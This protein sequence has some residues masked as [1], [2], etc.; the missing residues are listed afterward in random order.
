MT[1][2]GI[3]TRPFFPKIEPVRTE[4]RNSLQKGPEWI[5]ERLD[6][7]ILCET[8][9][10]RK[11]PGMAKLRIDTLVRVRL[12][13]CGMEVRPWMV[14]AVAL[15]GAAAA[16]AQ[17]IP[18]EPPVASSPAK[19]G[20]TPAASLAEATPNETVVD[21]KVSGNK[22][23]PLEK[24]LPHIRTRAGRPFDMELIQEDVRRLDRTGLFVNVH[25]YHQAAPGGRI[26]IFDVL[27]R[28][29]LH[30]VLFIG[31]KEVRK[32]V[33][34]KEAE[35]KVGDPA[36]PYAIEEARRKLEDFYHKKGFSGARITLLEGDKPDDRRAIFLI[37]E[38]TKQRIWKVE[39]I[40]NTI[41]DDGRLQ[42]Q[43]KSKPP[44]LY[45]FKGELDRKELEE[46][47]QRL[48]A[49]YRGLGFFRARIGKEVSFDEKQNWATVTFVIDE[50]PRYKIRNVSVIGNTKFGSD[51]LLTDLKLKNQE[52][53]NQAKMT[54]DQ[55]SIQDKY[56]G[57]G[58]VFTDVKA[59]PRFL[60]EADQLDLVYN[61]EEGDRYR[62]GKINIVIKG[63]YPHTKI[64]T[65]LNRLSFQPGDIVDIRQIRESE[66]RI[67]YSQLFE[68]NPASGSAPKIVF[69]APDVERDGEQ[70]AERPG[71]PG[72]RPSGPK[73]RGQSPDTSSQDH[74]LDVT[75][76]C[77]RYIGPMEEE[78]REE[79]EEGRGMQVQRGVGTSGPTSASVA[80]ATSNTKAPA[81]DL[82]HMANELSDSLAQNR[83]RQLSRERLI[84]MQQYTPGAPR[85]TQ[86]QWVS[87]QATAQTQTAP[88]AVQN[89]PSAIQYSQPAPA[90]PAPAYGQPMYPRTS[91]TPQLPAY[92][93]NGQP[94]TPGPIFD[95]S[96][97]FRDGPPEGGEPARPLPFDITAEETMT[98]RLMF[99]VGINSDAGLMGSVVLDEQNFDWTRFPNSWE[100]VRN[101]TA[102]R[103]AGQRFRMEAAPGTQV[104][105]YMVDFMEPYMFNTAVSMG[106]SGYYY[107]RFYT[108]YADQRVGGRVAFGYQFT[109]DLSGNIAYRGANINISNPVDPLLPDLQ[110]VVG[111]DLALHG[112]KLTLTHDKRD[113]A[114]LATEGH[115]FEVGAEQV[116]GSFEYPRLDVDLRKY[117]TLYERPD[118]SGR[119][120]L[121][122]SCRAGYTGDNT[123]IYERFYAGGFST[124]RGFQFR[125]ASPQE[126][127]P[128]SGLTTIVGGDFQLLASAEYLFPITADDMLRGVVFCDTGTVEPTINDWSN[129]YRVAPGFGLRIVVPAMG[130]AP[131]ALDFAFP[132]AW[133]PG[134]KGELFSF[135]M[136]FNR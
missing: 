95:E 130:P 115:L 15:W 81:S 100:D 8:Q 85:N 107:S 69:N 55:T 45:L 92:D 41:S 94:Y 97:P 77:G 127:N 99:G 46:D 113:N 13:L 18:S 31:C 65:I 30:E 48:T 74:P 131:I 124:I 51:E 121:S 22:S 73:Y 136:G 24:I 14:V 93:A 2:F 10:E 112:F 91:G 96:S 25:T 72:K 129:K 84:P 80:Y 37:N 4:R 75:L 101:A 133:Q 67:K 106:L 134:D 66:R 3:S 59:D 90:Q 87:G 120:V 11:E 35:I 105:R 17:E 104:Q 86:L 52:Y 119:Q 135:F 38:G 28:P 23:L 88:S 19:A 103:G 62:V 1:A 68:N 44:F 9:L 116:L 125:G 102:W 54:A 40:G 60:E 12:V 26:V 63:E 36:D 21:V 118:G 70:V 58:Y 49:Y 5:P 123:P 53:F 43:I 109:P 47:I 71:R 108:E 76:D 110:E 32:K 16:V 83:G 20:P 7:L 39:F 128:A 33:L 42:T 6:S 114:F 79:R 78:E 132:I 34:Q 117:F 29:L 122:L 111:R 126:F 89:P 64:T 98:G 82:L 56:G 57:I 50:G 27:E 61:I